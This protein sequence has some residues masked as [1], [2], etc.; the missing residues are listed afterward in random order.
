MI[1]L[2]VP[3]SVPAIWSWLGANSASVTAF[4]AVVSAVLVALGVARRSAARLVWSLIGPVLEPPKRN[5][6]AW[7]R[8]GGVYTPKGGQ[9]DPERFPNRGQKLRRW[10]R[11][12]L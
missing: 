11:P 3:D 4:G 2:P 5:W 8:A 10:F 9:F 7:W 1:C 6:S 12:K